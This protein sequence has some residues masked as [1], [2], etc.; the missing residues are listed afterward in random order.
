MAGRTT[1]SCHV[2]RD[3][4][5]G[6]SEI[7]ELHSG[8]KLAGS[9]ATSYPLFGRMTVTRPLCSNR[10]LWECVLWINH[11]ENGLT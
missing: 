4:A 8:A 7:T 10:C 1:I 6:V 3:I 11:R 2:E 9:S 5:H